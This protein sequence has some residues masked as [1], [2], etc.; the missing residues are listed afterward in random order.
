[1]HPKKLVGI[2]LQLRSICSESDPNENLGSV[3]Y[4]QSFL[5]IEATNYVCITKHVPDFQ[6]WYTNHKHFMNMPVPILTEKNLEC[7]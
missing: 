6:S 3:L 4:A 5:M 1:M 7:D 2:R